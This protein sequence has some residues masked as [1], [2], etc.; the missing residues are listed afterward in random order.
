MFLILFLSL[1]SISVDS[2]EGHDCKS[3]ALSF[4]NFFCMYSNHSSHCSGK[5]SVLSICNRMVQR[6]TCLEVYQLVVFAD[7]TQAEG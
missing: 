6:C 1:I 3:V 7:T 5:A 2:F 4:A